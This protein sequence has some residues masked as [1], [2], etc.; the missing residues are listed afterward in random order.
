MPS[1]LNIIDTVGHT[2]LV[3]LET[4]L[5][6]AKATVLV[7]LENRNPAGSVKC[8]VGAAMIE[9]AQRSGLIKEGIELIEPTSGNGHW[10]AFVQRPKDSAYVVMLRI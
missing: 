8:R 2:P 5:E 6:D 3:R 4:C 1:F 10:D 7:K 9:D